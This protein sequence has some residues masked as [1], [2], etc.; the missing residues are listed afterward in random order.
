MINN[1]LRT[2]F[3]VEQ[4]L[5]EMQNALQLSSKAAVMRL[6]IAYSL[7]E[8]KDPRNIQ[9]T[10]KQPG[11]DYSRLTIFGDDEILFKLMIEAHLGKRIPDE[12]F[13]PDLTNAHIARGLEILI[14]DYKLYRRKEKLFLKNMR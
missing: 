9:V 14:S 11:N 8:E 4:K 5:Q 3:E 2:T 6:S 1:R 10:S 13:F 12:E 7:K